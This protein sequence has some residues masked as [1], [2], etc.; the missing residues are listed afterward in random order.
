MESTFK[1]I[2]YGIN[3]PKEVLPD[4]SILQLEPSLSGFLKAECEGPPPRL[5]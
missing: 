5:T 4:L 2:Q 1:R 3:F